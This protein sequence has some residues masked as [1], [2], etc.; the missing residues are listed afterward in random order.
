MSSYI[1][2]LCSHLFRI[3]VKLLQFFVAVLYIIYMCHCI[4]AN[5]STCAYDYL[6]A[7]YLKFYYL[8]LS[9]IIEQRGL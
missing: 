9:V 5:V 4:F 6:F 8:L 7:V 3:V 1:L 2:A